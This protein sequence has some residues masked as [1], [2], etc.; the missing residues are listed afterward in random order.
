[1]VQIPTKQWHIP[2]VLQEWDYAFIQT[3]VDKAYDIALAKFIKYPDKISLHFQEWSG[4][5]QRYVSESYL[6]LKMLL[7]LNTWYSNHIT[8]S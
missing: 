8:V 1:M 2:V 4:V 6:T 7:W 3:N 5:L